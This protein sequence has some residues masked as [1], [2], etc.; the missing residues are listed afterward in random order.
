MLAVVTG[1]SSGIGRDIARELAGRGFD[2]VLVARNRQ[3]L[4][5][6]AD[7]LPV[8]SKILSLDLSRRENC[9]LLHDLLK[10]KR[11]DVFVNNAGFGQFGAFSDTDLSEELGMIELN[12]ESV[13][14]LTKLFLQ[15]FIRRDHGMILNVESSAA[16]MSGGPLKAT[17]YTSNA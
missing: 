16:F 17:Y 13:H 15:D 10:G 1:A 5:E 12:I 7:T 2:L 8:H 14:I 11:V 4:L 3:K 9:Y 6:L